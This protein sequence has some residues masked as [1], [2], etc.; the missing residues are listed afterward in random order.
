MTDRI[1]VIVM[2]GEL[3]AMTRR[4]IDALV[5]A[6]IGRQMPGFY[7]RDWL[8]DRI[9]QVVDFRKRG[10]ALIPV[11]CPPKLISRVYAVWRDVVK[12]DEVS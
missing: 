8:A 10:L 5:D 2:P 7:D 1:Q 6:G 4:V 11:G 9:E 3:P 12:E